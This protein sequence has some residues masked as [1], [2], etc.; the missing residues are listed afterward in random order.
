MIKNIEP[1]T[2][3]PNTA[4]QLRV[5]DVHLVLS[6]SA[7]VQWALLDSSAATLTVNRVTI[8]GVEYEN[9]GT[10]DEYVFNLV[11]SKLGLVI[12]E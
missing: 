7:S 12:D 4:T 10:D 8:E 1:V 6:Q 9:W 3:F 11:A 5:D 2:V